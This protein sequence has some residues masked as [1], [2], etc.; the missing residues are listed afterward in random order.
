LANFVNRY[1]EAKH[2][3]S[4]NGIMI[5]IARRTLLPCEAREGVHN[6]CTIVRNCHSGTLAA[7]A[8]A[9]GRVDQRD[10]G[11][12]GLNDCWRPAGGIALWVSALSPSFVPR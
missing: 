7:C 6:D 2:R 11:E 9:L 4:P 3:L 8:N 10:T 12:L 5:T 1:L